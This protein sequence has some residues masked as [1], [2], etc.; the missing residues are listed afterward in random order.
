MQDSSEQSF[1]DRLVALLGNGG[2]NTYPTSNGTFGG[3]KFDKQYKRDNTGSPYYLEIIKQKLKE[4]NPHVTDSNVE[5]ILDKLDEEYLKSSHLLKQNKHIYELLHSGLNI[6]LK[7]NGSKKIR[8]V[9]FIDTE[10]PDRNQFD[11]VSQFMY[12]GQDSDIRPDI[13]LFVNGFPLVISELKDIGRG[14]QYTSAIRDIHDY[15]EDAPQLFYSNLFNIASTQQHLRYGVIDA[16]E[17]HYNPWKPEDLNQDAQYGKTGYD[18]EDGI[19]SLCKPSRLID[20][21]E[22]FVLYKN[23]SAKIIPRHQQY[24]AT[25]RIFERSNI[26]QN[27]GVSGRGLIWHTQGSGKSITMYY[28][29]KLASQNG[30]Q[31]IILVDRDS[32]REQMG[33]ELQD[34]GPGFSDREFSV[35]KNKRQLQ[36]EISQGINVILTTVQMFEGITDSL[37]QDETFI[38]ADEAHREMEGKY[39]TGIESAF[40]Q[41]SE[42]PVHHFGFTGTPVQETT[43]TGRDT[44][45]H[46]SMTVPDGYT[47][48]FVEEHNLNQPYLHRYSM[49]QGVEEGVIVRVDF[50]DRTDS[51][52]WNL[53]KE[54]MNKK[55]RDRYE[56]EYNEKQL[57]KAISNHFTANEVAELPSRV[58]AL[59]EDICDFYTKNVRS[60]SV[61]NKSLV[62]VPTRKTAAMVGTQLQSEFGSEEV[63]VLYTGRGTDDEL[64]EKYHTSS[65]ERE[66]IRDNFKNSENP[67]ILVVCDMLLTGFDAPNLGTIFLDRDFD[68]HRLMQSIARANRAKNGKKF[69][70]IVDYWNVHKHIQSMYKNVDDEIS[71]YLS[72]NKDQFVEEY[73]GVLGELENRAKVH[74]FPTLVKCANHIIENRDES[75]FLQDVKHLDNLRDSIQP[76]QRLTEEQREERHDRIKRIAKSVKATTESIQTKNTVDPDEFK[77]TAKEIADDNIEVEYSRTSSHRVALE[78]S[79]GMPESMKV[80]I[81]K[82]RLQDEITEYADR[83]P[84]FKDLSERI[85]D[86]IKGWDSE[87]LSVEETHEKLEEISDELEKKL[88]PTK[89]SE[90]E[91]MEQ[92]I[93]DVLA[94]EIPTDLDID[95]QMVESILDDFIQNWRKT[96]NIEDPNYRRKQVQKDIKKKMLT[97]T[98]TYRELLKT[99]FCEKAT[100]YLARNKEREDHL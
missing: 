65:S 36:D 10:N 81:K 58:D 1:E 27:M 18:V 29:A 45:S 91:W 13:A 95:E 37:I 71:V 52:V 46:Y 64:L 35:I 32:L 72:Q 20:L 97:Q 82:R 68:D 75:E 42:F 60:R 3:T 30:G 87:E 49:K 24:F 33:S 26:A 70:E 2:W 73:S 14:K 40:P 21:F 63:Q 38:F 44:F 62:V 6:Q 53:D 39:G 16:S 78:V 76:D 86:I 100:E 41:S 11:A 77:E 69:G 96:R 99:D 22:N 88:T 28:A 4:L 55:L 34:M 54:E 51:F 43:S 61:A 93:V 31:S 12:R 67:K 19:L 15:E 74:T 7:Y 84:Q 47:D 8:T 83:S 90:E 48:E 23:E 9:Q 79:E 50:V 92:V 85:E 5:K 57:Q 89:M 66:T 17:T 98:N 80:S 59:V 25:K 56:R 94:E